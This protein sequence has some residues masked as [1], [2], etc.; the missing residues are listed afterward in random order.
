MYIFRYLWLALF[1]YSVSTHSINDNSLVVLENDRDILLTYNTAVALYGQEYAQ[2]LQN[3][4]LLVYPDDPQYAY[5]D[6]VFASRIR[7]WSDQGRVIP[8]TIS[9]SDLDNVVRDALDKIS[10]KNS[11]DFSTSK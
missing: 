3:Q 1:F 5:I 4:G 10:Q 9:N 2:T 8:Y 6:S 11:F 7:L